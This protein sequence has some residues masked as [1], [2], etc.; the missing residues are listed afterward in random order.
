LPFIKS[1]T[2]R[3]HLEIVLVGK[4]LEH[5]NRLIECRQDFDDKLKLTQSKIE[6]KVKDVKPIESDQEE[7]KDMIITE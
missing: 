5:L 1:K 4:E 6:S 7:E 2:K 3:T